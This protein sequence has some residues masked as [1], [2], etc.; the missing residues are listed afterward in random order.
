MVVD[1]IGHS[2]EEPLGTTALARWTQCVLVGIIRRL[3]SDIPEL[4][5]VAGVA[6]L[7]GVSRQTVY[8]WVRDGYLKPVAR[9]R[10]RGAS[11]DWAMLF[12]PRDLRGKGDR[13]H[14][15]SPGS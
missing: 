10:L 7:C 9:Y 1:T 13:R 6:E 12:S 14:R 3:V 8:N 15:V 4:L 2:E 11:G 5:T